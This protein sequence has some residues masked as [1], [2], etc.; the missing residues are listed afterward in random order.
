MRNEALSIH[1][2]K[3]IQKAAVDK[4]LSGVMEL[5]EH[6]G[7]NYPKVVRAWKG[8]LSITLTDLNVICESLDLEIEVLVKGS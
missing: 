6:C 1:V 7:L 2:S 4:G 3:T 8:N 5:V